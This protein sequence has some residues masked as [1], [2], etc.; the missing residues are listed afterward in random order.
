LT[1]APLSVADESIAFT[2]RGQYGDCQSFEPA[3]P[4]GPLFA[5][6]RLGVQ[7]RPPRCLSH[8]LMTHH[9]LLID[10]DPS[11]SRKPLPRFE[12]S[13]RSRPVSRTPLDFKIRCSTHLMHAGSNRGESR[14]VRLRHRGCPGFG[15]R[16]C[17]GQRAA[18]RWTSGRPG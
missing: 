5:Q 7:C 18:V 12:R 11:L 4:V 1:S 15:V 3:L 2:E 9:R 13:S 17:A 16:V 8:R 14:R 6:H 10:T